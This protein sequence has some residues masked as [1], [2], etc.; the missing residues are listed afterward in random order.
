MSKALCHHC[1]GR[2]SAAALLADCG[3]GQLNHRAAMRRGELRRARE[4]TFRAC[5]L[6][7]LQACRLQRGPVQLHQLP[8]R[9]MRV[10]CLISGGQLVL[11]LS[12]ERRGP[13]RCGRWLCRPPLRVRLCHRR[14]GPLPF[15]AGGWDH[16][17]GIFK[18]DRWQ[19]GRGWRR[20]G[21]QRP[22]R[23]TW[24]ARRRRYQS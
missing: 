8:G 18:T 17:L 15:A 21:R 16:G 22:W 10:P 23:W 19:A 4:P 1:D 12:C 24:P 14:D 2:H 9:C 11:G 3:H 13:A 7:H 20:G 5:L 6:A